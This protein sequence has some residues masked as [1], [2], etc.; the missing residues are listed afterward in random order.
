MSSLMS[1]TDPVNVNSKRN[2][3]LPTKNSC[4]ELSLR[5]PTQGARSYLGVKKNCFTHTEVHTQDT[6]ERFQYQN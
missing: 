2:L 6:V 1:S 5:A 3:V 4:F